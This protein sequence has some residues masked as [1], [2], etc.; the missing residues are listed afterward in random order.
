MTTNNAYL[1][2]WLVFAWI[3]IP[4]T[5]GFIIYYREKRKVPI[6]LI[7]SAKALLEMDKNG[8]LVPHGIGMHARNIIEE[9]IKI[10]QK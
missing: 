8:V 7:N 10:Y 2:I 4:I 6:G 3:I 1:D 9:F 5:V